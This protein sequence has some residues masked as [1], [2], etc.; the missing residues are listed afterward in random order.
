[1]CY[2]HV[3]TDLAV[4]DPSGDAI[5]VAVPGRDDTTIE[6]YQ[7]PDERLKIIIPRVQSIATGMSP[8]A[9]VHTWPAIGHVVQVVQVKVESEEYY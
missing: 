7:F 2:Q 4:R 9:F 1:M 5:L 6:V 3:S 8:D